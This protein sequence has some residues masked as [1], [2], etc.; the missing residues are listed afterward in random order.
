MNIYKRKS[1]W[2]I[3]LAIA[4]IAILVISLAYTT[5][6]AGK[7]AEQ[8]RQRMELW[9]KSISLL[10]NI[11]LNNSDPFID[12]VTDF[13]ADIGKSTNDIASIITDENGD[14]LDFNNLDT[15]ANLEYELARM[16]QNGDSIPIKNQYLSLF[17]HYNESNLLVMLRY[18][19][20]F[21]LA[22]IILFIGISYW[23]FSW[24]RR[25]EQNQVWVGLA[26]ETAHQLG[27][28]ITAIVAWIEMLKMMTDDN[29]ELKDI[30]EE[31]GKD[32]KRLEQITERFSKIG[33]VPEL[34]EQNILEVVKKNMD[35]MKRRAPRRV[36]FEYQ[37]VEPQMMANF[38]APLFDWVLENLL[39]NALDAMSREG[40][41]SAKV[42]G[43]KDFVIIDISDSG[44]G[45]PAGKLKT[46][47]KPGFSTKKRGWGLGLSLTERIIK[48]YHNG[49]IFVKESEIGKG[50]TF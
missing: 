44:K 50:T 14:F 3:Y 6:I 16:R 30:T 34:K 49:R 11:P 23:L 12:D 41:I 24:A 22:L 25:S 29:E 26:K 42:T 20:Y 27:T 4:G 40:K 5:Y 18:F 1:Q 8:E 46:V 15:S 39:R 45:I 43:T 17:A 21:Q 10:S 32:V 47:F 9:A 35:Y 13:L 48:N 28:P 33:A 7:I 36:V 38:N 31:L 37:P 19:P 2:K